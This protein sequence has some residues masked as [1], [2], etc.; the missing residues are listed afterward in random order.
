MAATVNI[1]SILGCFAYFIPSGETVDGSAVSVS[2]WPDNDPTTNWTNYAFGC[3][4]MAEPIRDF[5]DKE[6]LCPSQD[7]YYD[8]E[9][10]RF[11]KRYGYRVTTNKVN[12]IVLR[13]H[14][15]L[16]DAVA[17][18]TA[19]TPGANRD[20]YVDGVLLIQARGTDGNDYTVEQ[21]WARLRLT[22]PAGM[23]PE[24][25]KPVLE[26]VLQKNSLNT[27]EKPTPA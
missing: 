4:E 7:G 11:L 14:H 10:E 26:F 20:P 3:I 8:S 21:W 16:T 1:R 22:T 5:D 23:S 13:L 19:Q 17:A 12:D 24:F 18:D 6:V 9:T 2:S 27:W 25:Q 15:C